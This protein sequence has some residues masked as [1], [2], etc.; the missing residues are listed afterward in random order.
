LDQAVTLMTYVR[1]ARF[2][3]RSVNRPSRLSFSLIF[4]NLLRKIPGLNLKLGHDSFLP[5]PFQFTIHHQWIVRR[6]R[7]WSTDS[8]IKINAKVERTCVEAG[9]N[10]ARIA[11]SQCSLKERWKMRQ[12]RFD[13][14]AGVSGCFSSRPRLNPLWKSQPDRLCGLVVSVSD[15][16]SGGPGFDSRRYQIFWEIV[17]LERGPLSLVRIIEEL[18]G[19]KVAAPI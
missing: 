5:H 18:L 9:S 6:Y 12:V 11:R 4:L 10:M 1:G 16:R 2:E 14:S 15:Y 7:V 13:S 17:G 19:R 3:S 8:V